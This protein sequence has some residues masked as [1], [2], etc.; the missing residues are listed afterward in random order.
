MKKN[1]E[2]KRK[3]KN[4][5]GKGKGVSVLVRAVVCTQ[6]D[7]WRWVKLGVG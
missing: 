2:E 7:E 4:K 1:E 3:V 5:N 6:G